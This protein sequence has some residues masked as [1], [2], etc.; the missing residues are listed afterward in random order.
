MLADPFASLMSRIDATLPMARE[1]SWLALPLSSRPI[2]DDAVLTMPRRGTYLAVLV[3]LRVAGRSPRA[4]VAW[5]RGVA[6]APEHGPS[7]P[8]GTRG[9]PVVGVARAAEQ[10]PRPR[11]TEAGMA[12]WG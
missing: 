7:M 3:Q 2:I 11:T 12:A 9:G 6:A 5:C 4:C 1:N 8:R 10:R